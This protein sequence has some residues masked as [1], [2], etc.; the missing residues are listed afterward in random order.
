MAIRGLLLPVSI[1]AI[2]GSREK[3]ILQPQFDQLIE[4]QKA[5]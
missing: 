5:C 3:A 2:R 4:K 1:A